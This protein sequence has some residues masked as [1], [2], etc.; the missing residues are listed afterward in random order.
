ME[1]IEIKDN[2]I[3]DIKNDSKEKTNEE[4]KN[5]KDKKNKK[6]QN[7]QNL[8]E[9]MK[10]FL[11][12]TDKHRE[13]NCIRDAYNILNDVTEKIYPNL[14]SEYNNISLNENIKSNVKEDDDNNNISSKIEDEIKNLKKCKNIYTSFNTRCAAIIFIK[15]ENEYSKLISPKIIVEYIIKEV[16]ETK[17]S[18]SKLISKFYPIEVCAK[19]NLDLFKKKVDELVNKHFSQNIENFKTWKIELRVRNNSSIN[20]KELMNYILGKMNKEKYVVEYKNPELT[21]LV[22]ISCNMMCLSVLEKF[23]EYKSYNIQN[24]AKTEEELN[25]E[26]NKL[27]KIQNENK[28][29][30]KEEKDN[31]INP[32]DNEIEVPKE[33]DEIDLI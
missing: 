32:K 3:N 22:E 2:E 11:I 16:T 18:L 4:K 20:K 8:D 33:D 7:I 14:Y 10:G 23:A 28:K 17:K 31:K 13:K 6:Q 29:K 9:E 15:I 1:K 21:F 26:K 27:M 19:F 12:F 30:D 24:L 25:N 5:R